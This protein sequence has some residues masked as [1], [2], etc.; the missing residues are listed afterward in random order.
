[1][2]QMLPGVNEASNDET[3][4]GVIR[5]VILDD[6]NLFRDGCKEIDLALAGLDVR[7]MFVH[8]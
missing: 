1:M 3:Q 5:V 4:S 8:I 6:Q 2:V 7:G